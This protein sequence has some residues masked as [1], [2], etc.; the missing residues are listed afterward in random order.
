VSRILIMGTSSQQV[1]EM[2]F[3]LGVPDDLGNKVL[4]SLA[5]R[6][7]YFG[8]S[9]MGSRED[10]RHPVYLLTNVQNISFTTSTAGA[11]DAFAR[12]DHVHFASP[13]SIPYGTYASDV[14][15]T[16]STGGVIHKASRSDHKHYLNLG[17]VAGG[18][19]DEIMAK[20][21]A[22]DFDTKWTRNLYLSSLGTFNGPADLPIA[23]GSNKTI[24]LTD[25]VWDDLRI[26]SGSFSRP[27][28]SDPSIVLYYPA[29]GGLGTGLYEFAK[30]NWVSFV[31]QL[32]HKYKQGTDI[33]VHLHWTPGPNGV[34]EN[35]HTVGW[36]VD[37]AWANVD[38]TFGAMGTA[39]LSD[40][41]DG[42]DDKH[43]MT[44]EVTLDGHT[45]SKNISSML[46]CNLRRSDTGTDDTW[47][48]TVAG[49]LPMI[50]EVDFH[51]QIDTIGSR[52]AGVK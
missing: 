39:D 5:T 51:F 45:A 14:S 40:A 32:P 31:A 3:R 27:G 38:G 22:T 21:S 11:G 12:G 8:S 26:V 29:G 17:F 2:V 1:N 23:C 7:G 37:Y 33:K 30:N 4:T 42:T 13:G 28:G 36:K 48:G 24:S 49:A 46:I 18:A 44:P 20:S 50:L 35:G 19:T 16:T 34:T 52:Q 43:Q 9:L 47:V 15:L 10:H 6:A 25:A 41:C